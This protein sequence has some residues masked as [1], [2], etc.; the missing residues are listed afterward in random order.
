MRLF[1]VLF[2]V[3]LSTAVFAEVKEPV[4]VVKLSYQNGKLALRDSFFMKGFYPQNDA[5]PSAGYRLA[6]LKTGEEVYSLRFDIPHSQFVDVSDPETGK[7]SGGEVELDRVDFALT[8][9][10]PDG[11]DHI[12]IYNDHNKKVIE[13]QEKDNSLY[14]IFFGLL[15][16]IIGIILII[17]T[18]KI[19]P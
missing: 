14:F 10:Y 9:P 1:V 15:L 7:L 12:V 6:V 2:L 5:Q 19:R 17:I 3:I 13:T 11:S 8:V 18:K 4:V 16:G